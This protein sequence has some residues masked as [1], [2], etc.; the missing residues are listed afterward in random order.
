VTTQNLDCLDELTQLV[1]SAKKIQQ[2]VTE[3]GK[4]FVQD[5]SLPLDLRWETFL[6]LKLG[7]HEGWIVQF[8]INDKF[9]DDFPISNSHENRGSR[10]YIDDLDGMLLE[11]LEPRDEPDPPEEEI[12]KLLSNGQGR[13][14]YSDYHVFSP[15]YDR[16]K[17]TK[18]SKDVIPED[19]APQLV[20]FTRE[21]YDRWRELV[22]EM[23]IKSYT[24]D[25]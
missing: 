1:D 2:R 16:N 23:Y 6:K 3:K 17:N 13:Y 15:Y 20:R 18:W 14:K 25:W 9:P 19:I 4:A 12:I 5:T 7:D 10:I 22:L 24:Y 8:N 11:M 21:D